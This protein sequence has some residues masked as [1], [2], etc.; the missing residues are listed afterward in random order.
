ML[1][2]DH[3]KLYHFAARQKMRHTTLTIPKRFIKRDNPLW[4]ASIKIRVIISLNQMPDVCAHKHTHTGRQLN[5]EVSDKRSTGAT[6][7]L[8]HLF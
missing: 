8:A 1:D 7:S 5:M 2:F 3:R 6:V 4:T